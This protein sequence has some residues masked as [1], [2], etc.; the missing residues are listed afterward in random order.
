LIGLVIH[1]LHFKTSYIFLGIGSILIVL[2]ARFVSVF[3]P[4]SLLKH[5]TK[6]IM[7]TVTILTIGGLRGGI[8]IALALSLSEDYSKEP[9][10]FITYAVV[11]FSIVVQGLNLGRVVKK[12][13]LSK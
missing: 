12:L 3:L 7:K 13:N 2:I 4:F 10:L 6:S 1:L 9:I 11:L 8:S 5:D